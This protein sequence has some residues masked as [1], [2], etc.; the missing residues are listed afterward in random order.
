MLS[1]CTGGIPM[2]CPASWT[3]QSCLAGQP[4]L[5]NKVLSGRN[6]LWTDWGVKSHQGSLSSKLSIPPPHPPR[7]GERPKMIL[8]FSCLLPSN[9]APRL[10]KQSF[11]LHDKHT[12]PLLS[13]SVGPCHKPAHT[14]FSAAQPSCSSQTLHAH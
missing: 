12:S 8:S 6:I 4:L 2:W 10:S 5:D 14:Q 9:D 3:V 11:E 1:I 13:P 7:H